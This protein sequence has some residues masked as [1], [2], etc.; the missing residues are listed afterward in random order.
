[1]RKVQQVM[2]RHAKRYLADQQKKSSSSST[3]S[4]KK[5]KTTKPAAATTQPAQQDEEGIIEMGKDGNFDVSTTTATQIAPDK[6]PT[7]SRTAESPKKIEAVGASI[8]N[9]DAAKD[10]APDSNNSTNGSDDN[11]KSEA[12]SSK[13]EIPTPPLGNG[14]TVPGKYSWTQ[15]LSEVTVSVPV[16][17]NTR[18]RDLNITIAKKTLKVGLRGAS[19][20]D[21]I[22][23]ETPLCKQIIVDDSFWTVEDGNRLVINLQKSNQMEWWDCVVQG[24]PT[25]DVKAIQPENSSLSDLDG[26]TRKTVEKMMFDQRQKAM[27]RPTSDE[28][29]KLDVLEQFKKEHPELDF[30]NAKI[31]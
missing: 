25:I 7:S 13:D 31:T 28:Q 26:E 22:I 20:A 10:A 15:T 11:E 30:S 12:S 19:Q 23:P 2:E 29:Q 24:D 1:M 14:G 16:P 5:N 6:S 8:S 27:G 17:D 21:M 9:D 4:K 18:G 3:S